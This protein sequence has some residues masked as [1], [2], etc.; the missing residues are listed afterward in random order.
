MK[1][2]LMLFLLLPTIVFSQTPITIQ[3]S[4]L[5]HGPENGSLI[6]IGG[7]KIT[8]EIWAKFTELAGGVEKANIVVITAAL[9][10]SAALNSGSVELLK[11]ETN[12]SRVTFLHTKDLVIANSKEFVSVLKKAT[13]V[14]FVGGRQW[15]IADSYLN[16]L[17]HQAFFEVLNRGGV[18]AG[19]SAG[20]SIQGSLLWRG[21]TS[22][23]QVLIGDHTQGLGFLR[24]S[25]IDQHLLTRNRM[26]DLIEI[27]K[28]NPQLIGV[29]LD[30]S[31][32]VWIR[33]DTLEV[34]GKSYVAIYDYSTIIGNELKHTVNKDENY[35]ASNGPFFFLHQ[36]QRYDLGTRMVIDEKSDTNR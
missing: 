34:I 16:T 36:G 26:F 24:N 25:V 11:K 28:S 12:I 17:T 21:D 13:G 29:G 2:L 15:R 23:A 18:I 10:D 9:G 33:R 8:P 6:L 31:T 22:G 3:H 5:R 20:A 1:I 7:G 32:A 4:D 27:I 35:S 19:T 14:F 30:E